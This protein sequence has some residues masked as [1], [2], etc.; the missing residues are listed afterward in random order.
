VNVGAT[1]QSRT[2]DG[3]TISFF[4]CFSSPQAPLLYVTAVKMSSIPVYIG[5]WQDHSRGQILGDTVTLDVRWG[6]YLIAA[7]STFV[8]LVG[9]ALWSLTAFIVHQY[10]A[11]PGE[12]DGVFFHQ[13]VVYRNQGSTAGAL[14][15]LIKICWA[16]RSKRPEGPRVTRLKRRSCFYSLPPLLIFAVFTAAGVFISEV[17]GSTYGSNSVRVK[18]SRCGFFSYDTSTVEGRRAE[19]LKAVNDTLSSRQYAK[20][21][22]HSN[23]TFSDC[24]LFPVQSLPYNSSMVQCPFG[25]DPSGQ[26]SC[27]PGSGEALQMD[28]GLLDTNQ[29]L[30]INAAPENRLLFRNIVTCSPIRIRDY[31]EVLNNTDPA[32]PSLQ[33]DMGS[34]YVTPGEGTYVYDTHTRADEVAYQITFVLFLAY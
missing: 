27:I 13:Q 28:T 29:H 4:S 23:A 10:R 5:R 34:V 20:T 14:L 9:T 31:L 30:G 1:C 7:L 8:G 24:T 16:W 32:F 3:S 17:A 21:C 12:E 11:R 2:D 18:S 22:Y 25:A 33:Y 15:D 6:G 19:D 26:N